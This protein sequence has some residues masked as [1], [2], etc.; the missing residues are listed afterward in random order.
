MAKH[1]ALALILLSC[2]AGVGCATEDEAPSFTEETVSGP[3]PG[4][5]D[6]AATIEFT[7]LDFFVPP[8]QMLDEPR[9]RMMTTRDSFERVFGEEA[10]FFIDFERKWV[11]L[12]TPGA[13]SESGVSM[14]V[15]EVR[16]APSGKS[17]EVV[18]T[19]TDAGQDCQTSAY[20]YR[21]FKLITFP[22][23]NVLPQAVRYYS[24]QETT[25][26]IVSA[27]EADALSLLTAVS[28]GVNHTSEGD[29]SFEAFLVPGAAAEAVDDAATVRALGEPEG[30]PLHSVAFDTWFEWPT[31]VQNP[32]DA[33]HVLEVEAYRAIQK[34]YQDRFTHLRVI[35]VGEVEVR[36]YLVGETP[37]GDLA[38]L[39]TLSIET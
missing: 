20:D 8:S 17:I 35:R 34:L 26:C 7:E 12:A 3:P 28:E 15:D 16:V 31:E 30:E 22:K 21:P 29:A 5:A 19:T 9:Y 24:A 36:V 25:E 11:V 14:R 32:D 1:T 23:P 2:F 38:V 13:Q 37:C 18:T 39:K 4:K 33:S 6:D 27:C 10:P